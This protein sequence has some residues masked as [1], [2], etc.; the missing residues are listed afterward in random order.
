MLAVALIPSIAL[1][2]IG[3]VATVYLVD[4]GQKDKDWAE[5]SSSVLAPA[6]VLMEAFQLERSASMMYLAGDDVAADNLPLTWKNSDSALAPLRDETSAIDVRSDIQGDLSGIDTLYSKL[7]VLRQGIESRAVTSEQAFEAY[8]TVIDTFVLGSLA[9]ASVA[10]DSK[11]AVDIYRGLHPL[12]AAEAISRSASIGATALLTKQLSAAQLAELT[13]YIGDSRG[14]ITYAATVLNAQ[15][16]AQLKAVTDSKEWRELVAMEDAVIRRGVVSAE[17]AGVADSG[18]APAAASSGRRSQVPAP[19]LPLS[20]TQWD[21]T[22]GQVRSLL[23]KVSG[24]QILD[25]HLE[26]EVAGADRASKSL[27]GGIGIGVLTLIT[28]LVALLLANRLIGRMHQLRK[29]T[30][31]L[32]DEGLPETIRNLSDGHAIDRDIEVSVLDFG[33]DEIGQ[34]ADAFNRAHS[35]AIDAAVAEARTRAG[36]NAVF[37]NIARRSQV[38]VHRQL[39]L[40]D[41]AEREEENP[42]KLGIL[43]QL[44]HLATRARRNA[45]NLII[46]GGEQPG[47]RW[48]NPVPLMDVVRGA[49]AESLDYARIQVLRLPEIQMIGVSVADLIHLLAELTD[50]ATSFSPPDSRV[51]VSGALVGKGVAIEISDQGIGMTADDVIDRNRL[52]ADPPGF[53]LGTLSSDARLGLFVVAKLAARHNISVR[54]S[55]SDYGG[56]RAVV[57]IPAKVI[58]VQGESFSPGN[59]HERPEFVPPMTASMPETAPA[60]GLE[61]RS[62]ADNADKPGLPRRQRTAFDQAAKSIDVPRPAE[63]APR[64]RSADE[65]RNMMSAIENGTRQGRSNRIDNSGSAQPITR[66]RSIDDDFR[67]P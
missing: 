24:G 62:S 33:N 35:A 16:Q 51:E 63:S 6:A 5:Y 27:R 34:V 53:G 43:F 10:P 28:F 30:L 29:Q 42:D 19:S 15:R 39:T 13:R 31:Q 3:G 20:A 41:E 57:L 36:V 46:L 1:L 56:V 40:L 26:A 37:I 52:L 45:E 11:I 44:D 21:S 9:V 58:A 61:P 14:E 18:S 4:D 55:E 50:N 47:R 12:R 17:E 25:A 67:A 66:R 54:L 59:N 8:N 22:A 32:A 60:A 2:S 64:Q 48:R 65:A 49:V 38:M 23:L 7:P